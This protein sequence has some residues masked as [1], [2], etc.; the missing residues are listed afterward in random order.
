M[1]RPRKSVA[2]NLKRN[3]GSNAGRLLSRLAEPIPAGA[4]GAAPAHLSAARKE[5]WKSVARSVPAGVATS[6]DQIAFELLVEL[7]EAQRSGRLGPGDRPHL[8]RL[9]EQ[10]GL[11]PASRSKVSAVKPAEKRENEWSEFG[12]R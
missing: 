4:L 10:F 7:I 9:L 11:T 8:L 3:F 2:E 12:G 1:A 6:A 5:L